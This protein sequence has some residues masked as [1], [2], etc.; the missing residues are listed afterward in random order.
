MCQ[1]FEQIAGLAKGSKN[2]LT[3]SEER[4][5]VEN[6]SLASASA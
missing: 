4:R 5:E 6:K 2:R 3:Q 1:S